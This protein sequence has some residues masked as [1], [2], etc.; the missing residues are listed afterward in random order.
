MTDMTDINNQATK[1]EAFK[2]SHRVRYVHDSKLNIS[3]EFN[4]NGTWFYIDQSGEIECIGAD[5]ALSYFVSNGG[6]LS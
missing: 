6:K 2:N 4:G 1:A 3:V 5:H